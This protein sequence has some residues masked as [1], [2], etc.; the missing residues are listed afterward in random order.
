MTAPELAAPSPPT[1]SSARLVGVPTPRMCGVNVL[2]VAAVTKVVALSFCAKVA[3]AAAVH[4]DVIVSVGLVSIRLEANIAKM[5]SEET[6][7]TRTAADRP[8]PG[9]IQA[10]EACVFVRFC[11]SPSP[12]FFFF[13]FFFFL[14]FAVFGSSSCSNSCGRAIVS[15]TSSESGAAERICC[16]SA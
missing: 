2:R 6:Q 12:V 9:K 4:R 11:V 16:A 1:K 7:T 13:F 15:S 10:V 5:M 8:K 14:F 3:P